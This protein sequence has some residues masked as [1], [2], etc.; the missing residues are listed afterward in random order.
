LLLFHF[1]NR[2]NHGDTEGTEK[3]QERDTCPQTCLWLI[4]TV[5]DR[6]PLIAIK[7]D[8]LP[9]AGPSSVSLYVS[10]VSE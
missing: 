9:C 8:S 2:F 4:F 10:F 1:M 6:Q 7:P 5:A 3:K